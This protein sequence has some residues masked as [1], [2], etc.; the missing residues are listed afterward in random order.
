MELFFSRLEAVVGRIPK[1]SEHSWAIG[2]FSIQAE[3]SNT[4]VSLVVSHTGTIPANRP[5]PYENDRK[6]VLRMQVIT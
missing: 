2:L 4:L 3:D 6:I 5:V 1:V